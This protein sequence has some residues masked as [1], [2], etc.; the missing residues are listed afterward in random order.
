MDR[1]TVDCALVRGGTSKGVYVREGELPNENRD[2]AILALFGSPDPRQIDG[3]GGGTST[4]SKLMIVGDSDEDGVDAEFT[5]G[6]VSTD[7]RVVDYGGTCGNLTFGIGAFAIDE[8]IVPV[9]DRA[10]EV[11]LSLY[12]TNTGSYVEQTVPLVNGN[13]RTNGDFKIYGVPRTYARIDSTFLDPA[14]GETGSLFPLGGPTVNLRTPE[15]TVEVSVLDVVNPVVFARPETVGLTGTELPEEVDNNPE[16]LDRIE[17][18]RAAAC[19]ALDYVDNAAEASNIS[20]GVP[21]MAFVTGPKMYRSSSDK[22]IPGEEIDVTARIMSMQKLHPVYAVSGACCTA[23]ATLL[24]GTVPNQVTEIEDN[25]VT[26][27]HPKGP[28]SVTAEVNADEGIVEAV[29]VPRT[30]RRLIE[31]TAF[32]QPDA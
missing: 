25:Q 31:G 23:A 16:L 21:K 5:F 18:I 27:G 17:Q 11:T 1:K 8:R 22:T 29:T 2:K 28:M 4:T 14:G 7:Q 10:E 30:Q 26:I 3:L 15:R 9:D 13:A 12:N 19:E 6:Q 24:P 32:F 20:P